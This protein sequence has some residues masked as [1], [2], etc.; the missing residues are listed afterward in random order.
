M[1]KNKFDELSKQIIT[2]IDILLAGIAKL[3]GFKNISIIIS[4]LKVEEYENQ[5]KSDEVH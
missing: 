3:R 5:N 1:D 2:M 4:G